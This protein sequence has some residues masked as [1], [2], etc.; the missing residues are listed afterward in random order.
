MSSKR[1][2]MEIYELN[3][4]SVNE[5]FK[6]PVTFIKVHKAELPTIENPQYS[7]LIR[8]N[9][10]LSGVEITDNDKKTQLSVHVILRSGEY[11]RIKTQSKP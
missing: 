6:M 10:H 9:A 2:R 3:T 8:N 11:A 7:E 1:T 5:D 4:E